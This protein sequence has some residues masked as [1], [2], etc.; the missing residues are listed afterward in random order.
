ML[1]NFCLLVV[2][3]L[4]AELPPNTKT[5]THVHEQES[6]IFIG[7]KVPRTYNMLAMLS[8]YCYVAAER[9]HLS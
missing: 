6:N 7:F 1:S 4:F 2:W 5:L 3:N 9:V 8:G